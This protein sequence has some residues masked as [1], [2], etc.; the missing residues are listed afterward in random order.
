MEQVTGFG[1]FFFRSEQ[2]EVLAQ[3][4]RDALGIDLVPKTADQNPWMAEG[5]ATVFAP[6]SAD[7]TYFSA[8]KVFMLNFRVR[9]LAAMVAQLEAAGIEV[10][11]LDEMPGIGKFAHLSDPEGTPIE[12][13]EPAT[14]E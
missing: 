9:D 5:G 14:G 10:N 11:L 4:Y 12:L 6:F 3:W 8:D 13:W 1:G 7:T 2:P